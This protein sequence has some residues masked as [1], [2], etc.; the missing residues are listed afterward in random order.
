MMALV[1]AVGGALGW[2]A[3][4]A[5]VQQAAVSAILK[6]RGAAFYNGEDATNVGTKARGPKWLRRIIGRDVLDRVT[7]VTLTAHAGFD[8]RLM[9]RIG[10]LSNLEIL[11]LNIS[12]RAARLTPRGASQIANLRQLKE[13]RLD[14]L[15]DMREFIPYIGELKHLH[16]LTMQTSYATD[17]DLSRLGGLTELQQLDTSTKNV[18]SKGFAQLANLRNLRHLALRQCVVDDL[19]ALVGM[20]KLTSLMLGDLR[21][22]ATSKGLKPVSLSPLF[23]KTKLTGIRLFNIPTD[24]ANLVRIATLPLLR[25]VE[26]SGVGVTEK[27]LAELSKASALSFLALH[28]SSVRDL[29]PLGAQIRKISMLGVTGCPITDDGLSPIATATRLST[30]NLSKTNVTDAGLAH[31]GTLGRL[32]VLS[33]NGTRITD[34]GLANLSRLTALRQ[35][36]LAETPVRG[37]GLSHL[38]GATQLLFLDLQSSAVTDEGLAFLAKLRGLKHLTLT[39]TSISDSG[40]AQLKAAKSVEVLYLQRTRIT[41]D[42]LVHLAGMPQLRDLWLGQTKITDDGLA[43]LALVRSLRRVVAP[44]TE[45]TVHGIAKLKAALPAVRVDT[46]LRLGLL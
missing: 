26:V 22:T 20:T 14:G 9:S 33:L 21:P 23:D 42:G 25:S 4:R 38:A 10:A 13:L 29:R 16:V 44:D 36:E 28:E 11:G 17:E 39:G 3:Y 37:S 5:R 31:L 18:T 30:L 34:D 8:D 19:S 32:R 15:A 35:F 41:D 46:S 24:D 7:F 6:A 1:L 12:P 40:L 43:H 2:I 27:S 45:I